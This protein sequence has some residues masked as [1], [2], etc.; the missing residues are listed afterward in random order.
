MAKH[1]N[2]LAI[3][4]RGLHGGSS[5]AQLLEKKRGVP[6]EKNLPKLTAGQILKWADLH[7]EKTGKWPKHK[8]GN[9][10][11]MQYETWFAIDAALRNNCRGLVGSSSLAQLLSKK[12]GV[13]N[14]LALPN[15]TLAQILRWADKH[16]KKTGHWPKSTSGAV[17]G[18]TGEKW[19]AINSALSEGL[20]GLRGGTTLASLLESQRG[21]RNHLTLG[22]LTIGQILKWADAHHKKTSE[23]P[24]LKSGEVQGAPGE[25]WPN[26]NAILFQ[27]GRGLPGGSSLA[28]LLTEKR[29]VR[30]LNAP[31]K[32]TI[33]QILKWA[34]S[35]HQ[36][37]G[38]WPKESSGEVLGVSGERWGNISNA[39]L[40]GQRGLPGG[41][42]LAKLLAEKRGVR[43]RGA[44]P[45]LSVEQI[46]KWADAHS[47]KTGEWPKVK[48]GAVL[49]ALGESWGIIDGSLSRGRRGL[50]GGSSLAKLL[51][52]KRPAN[53][54]NQC[55]VLK[56]LI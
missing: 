56:D 18:T 17:E 10:H 15:L 41:S 24:K 29:G 22:K 46:L 42:S 51:A 53:K 3:G 47:K 19:S 4:L 30:V 27:G 6:N 54:F 35:Y 55:H 33:Q 37:T 40:Q 26:I 2:A 9:V 45:D 13:R 50:S 8:S 36:V 38:K 48:S 31:P 44:L 39:L 11:G 5:L 16:S 25:K 20:R 32:L 14:K 12:R 43:N 52:E 23:W 49:G 21:V 34:D 28:K 1:P 7:H